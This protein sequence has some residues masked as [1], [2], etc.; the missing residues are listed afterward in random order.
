M[1]RHGSDHLDIEMSLAQNPLGCLPYGR[2]GLDG[3]V[4]ERFPVFESLTEVNGAACQFGVGEGD[5]PL[6]G[7]VDLGDDLLE[8]L[9][10]ATFTG[11]E[12]LGKERNEEGLMVSGRTP[13]LERAV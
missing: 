4:V 5:K 9:E 7:G 10:G 11:L 3:Q 8:L 1:E 2:K 13:K 6:F 12:D